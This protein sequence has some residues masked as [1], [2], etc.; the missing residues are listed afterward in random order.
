MEDPIE[1][2]GVP[3]P[4]SEVPLHHA[5]LWQTFRY[6]LNKYVDPKEFIDDHHGSRSENIRTWEDRIA[7]LLENHIQHGHERLSALFYT[8]QRADYWGNDHAC[9][10]ILDWIGK[11][12]L[13]DSSNA[14]ELL[15][16]LQHCSGDGVRQL[17]KR[18]PAM[19]S[20]RSRTNESALHRTVWYGTL[21]A[22]KAI[23]EADQS[24]E[25]LNSISTG[26][27]T[28][29]DFAFEGGRLDIVNYLMDH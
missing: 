11:P 9:D 20:I 19:L 26:G 15:D 2:R 22:V 5:L 1:R 13:E 8:F 12:A 23:V 14:V 17:L 16:T 6:S 21:D 10:R 3:T 7:F 24:S 18:A 25:L 27:Q 28:P 4:A 29:L